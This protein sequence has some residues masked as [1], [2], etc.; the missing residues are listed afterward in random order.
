M[1]FLRSVIADARPHKPMS[2]P[3]AG[4]SATTGWTSRGLDGN[5]FG[6]EGESSSAPDHT[7]RV[8]KAL[9]RRE[10]ANDINMGDALALRSDNSLNQSFQ[11]MGSGVEL[12]N[13]ISVP[14]DKS[15]PIPHEERS[16]P[17][18]SVDLSG[19]Q[20]DP[21]G[22][23]KSTTETSRIQQPSDTVISDSRTSSSMSQSHDPSIRF[24]ET[25][26]AQNEGSGHGGMNPGGFPASISDTAAQEEVGGVIATDDQRY[27]D[28]SI[29]D[30]APLTIQA[31]ATRTT[32][33]P[34]PVGGRQIEFESPM[35]PSASSSDAFGTPPLNDSAGRNED[36]KTLADDGKAHQVSPSVD[37][38]T[39][40]K[41]LSKQEE[42][43]RLPE[44]DEARDV[45]GDVQLASHQKM[46]DSPR[47]SD[48]GLTSAAQAA[49]KKVS[50]GAG[51]P[52]SGSSTPGDPVPHPARPAKPSAT[53]EALRSVP[54]TPFQTD[55]MPKGGDSFPLRPPLG[56]PEKKPEAPKVRIGQIDV[57][58]EAAKPPA[59]KSAPAPS[60]SDLASRLYLRRL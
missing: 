52:G 5:A 6:A 14:A 10:S 53:P 48:T 55:L 23:K 37:N 54:A 19:Q 30:T 60:S 2:E 7:S 12:E 18:D 41:G 45:L 44:R 57:I 51:S 49:D 33:L 26:D 47:P 16:F 35:V 25:F 56:S 59:A 40:M 9:S 39:A 8:S 31:D 11:D 24:S 15:E 46:M 36:K 4:P 58:I 28:G 13:S 17:L 22:E 21:E 29:K 50:I 43:H 20:T 34:L 3:L 27:S 32:P 42:T 38:Q 1:N